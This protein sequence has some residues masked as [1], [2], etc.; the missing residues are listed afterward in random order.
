M[1][2]LRSVP[3]WAIGHA[4]SDA[5]ID[6]NVFTTSILNIQVEL[7][8]EKM[9]ICH[10]IWSLEAI[11]YYKKYCSTDIYSQNPELLNLRTN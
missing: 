6:T 8:Q 3:N 11:L 4:L 10:D 2:N 5:E 9:C 1:V 7:L